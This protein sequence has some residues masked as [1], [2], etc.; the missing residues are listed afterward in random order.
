MTK[1]LTGMFIKDQEGRATIAPKITQATEGCKLLSKSAANGEQP[2]TE[3]E[4]AKRDE[5]RQAKQTAQTHPKP[6]EEKPAKL[7]EER[8][9]ETAA[10][11]LTQLNEEEQRVYDRQIRVWGVEAQR[12]LRCVWRPAMGRA[13]RGHHRLLRATDCCVRRACRHARASTPE[14]HCA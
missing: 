14:L 3:E 9:T 10:A 7:S 11:H 2:V 5:K 13:P 12:N 1:H 4:L 6:D 8:Q